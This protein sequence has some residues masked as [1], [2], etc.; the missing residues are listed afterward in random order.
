MFHVDNN[1]PPTYREIMKAL[2]Y[3]H[4]SVIKGHVDRMKV[5]GFIKDSK[6]IIAKG[7][8]TTW[9]PKD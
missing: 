5:K 3:N 2:G 9:D 8:K 1:R 6:K 4:A 7:V